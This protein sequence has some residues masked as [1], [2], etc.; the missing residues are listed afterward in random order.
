MEKLILVCF[1]GIFHGILEKGICIHSSIQYRFSD[2]SIEAQEKFVTEC[3][4]DAI[5]IYKDKYVI[6]FVVSGIE[7]DNLKKAIMKI[8]AYNKEHCSND[9]SECWE[10]YLS[11]INYP[12][13]DKFNR[14]VV[15]LIV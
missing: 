15:E 10:D 1:N 3:F 5:K 13:F 8:I 14:K 7:K 6:T 9:G 11:M 2:K 4:Q 12:S